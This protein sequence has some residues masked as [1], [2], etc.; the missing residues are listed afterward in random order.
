MKKSRLRYIGLA[1]VPLACAGCA[2]VG[3]AAGAVGPLL[4]LAF[5]A[6]LIALPFVA[7]Y[8]LWYKD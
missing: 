8:Y 1:V 2:S 7:S 4:N 5:Y 3:G 6:A